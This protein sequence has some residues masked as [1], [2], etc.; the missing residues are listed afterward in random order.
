MKAGHG[1]R[2]LACAIAAFAT[3]PAHAATGKQIF[4]TTCV[5]CHGA[6]AQGNPSLG[7]PALAGQSAAYL[8]RQ[9]NDFRSGLRGANP[10]D[11]FGGQ[12]RAASATLTDGKA[13]AAVAAY[14]ASLPAPVVKPAANANLR[15]G[16]NFYQGKCGACHGGRA[17]GIASMSTPRLSGLD[18][19][20]ITR[21]FH[22]FQQGLRGSS[23]QDRYGRQ[24]AMMAGTLPK[25]SD[26]ADVI[27]FIHS[28]GA[29]K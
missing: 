3:H 28:Q 17:E 8:E 4:G 26:L 13:I 11:S 22:G 7:A 19:A 25:E 5:A 9:L 15:N 1:L 10:K 2:L 14:L 18:A 27:A 29:A 24:M 21:Q 23:P 6:S 12:M 20:Y 16:N